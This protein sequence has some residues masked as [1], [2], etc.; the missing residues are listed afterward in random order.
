MRSKKFS[1]FDSPS[2]FSG[3][4]EKCGEIYEAQSKTDDLEGITFKCKKVIC[5]GRVTLAVGKAKVAS[6]ADPMPA[7]IEPKGSGNNPRRFC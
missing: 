3:V 1:E 6:K 2:F 7:P 5:T 4:C